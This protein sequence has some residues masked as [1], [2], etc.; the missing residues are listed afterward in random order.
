MSVVRLTDITTQK[1]QEKE[2]SEAKRT[3]EVRC[4]CALS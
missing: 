1:Q 2:V 3:L 4:R